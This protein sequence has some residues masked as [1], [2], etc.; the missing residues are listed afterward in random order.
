MIEAVTEDG[1]GA[2]PDIVGLQEVGNAGTIHVPGY[3]AHLH[4]RP[5]SFRFGGC[6]LLVR[7]ELH[8]N[9]TAVR[10]R[11]HVG[12][13]RAGARQLEEIVWVRLRLAD[14]T[15]L[16]VA[17][18]HLAADRWLRSPSV[19][20]SQREM[21]AQLAA[22]IALYS[23]KGL[24]AVL[25][26][27][28]RE[29]DDRDMTSMVQRSPASARGSKECL[30]RATGDLSTKWPNATARDAA[31]T[32]FRAGSRPTG[33][34]NIDH[35]YATVS[36]EQCV[37]HGVVYETLC[38]DGHEHA[39]VYAVLG[40]EPAR[41]AAS[42][43]ARPW[44]GPKGRGKPDSARFRH[45]ELDREPTDA[46]WR[47]DTAMPIADDGSALTA[48]MTL[49]EVSSH[50]TKVVRAAATKHAPP[51][52]Q[53][54]GE[55][56]TV[57]FLHASGADAKRMLKRERRARARAIAANNMDE[58]DAC[59]ARLRVHRAA[60][61]AALSAAAQRTDRAM[62]ESIK[63]ATSEDV[64]W[65]LLSKLYR[66]RRPPEVPPPIRVRVGS[67]GITPDDKTTAD[68]FR[69]KYD[70]IAGTAGRGVEE[71]LRPWQVR[72]RAAQRAVAAQLAAGADRRAP[73]RLDA[74]FTPEE[75]R[76]ALEQ[77]PANKAPGSDRLTYDLYKRV[78]VSARAWMLRMYNMAFTSGCV[79]KSW[80][81]S[82]IYV[83]HKKGP[84]TEAENYRLLYHANTAGKI[85]EKLLLNR[86]V[87]HLQSSGLLSR[88]QIG[89]LKK[90]SCD[91]HSFALATAIQ[92][93]QPDGPGEQP[94]FVAFL[95]SR[96]A[97][98]TTSPRVVMVKLWDKG[99][100]GK[101][102][103]AIWSTFGDAEARIHIGCAASAPF[104]ASGG[105]PEGRCASPI[106]YLVFVD[107]LIATLAAEPGILVGGASGTNISVLAFADDIA[108][109]ASS[110]SGLQRLLD[111]AARYAHEHAF[112]FSQKKSNTMVVG[113]GAAAVPP[114]A[115]WT[116][117]N[118]Y[119]D[120]PSADN[121][122]QTVEH[123]EYLG[124][125][126][127]SSGLWDEHHRLAANLFRFRSRRALALWGYGAAGLGSA[128]QANL[129]RSV[130]APVL[131]KSAAVTCASNTE[132][133]LH[134]D[135]PNSL[136][137]ID[138][139]W[140]ETALRAIGAPR[141]SHMAPIEDETGLV[142]T[143]ARRHAKLAGYIDRV[144]RMPDNALVRCVLSHVI[145]GT[146]G[147]KQQ[148]AAVRAAS[149]RS[150]QRWDITPTHSKH[151]ARDEMRAALEDEYYDGLDDDIG[152]APS[153]AHWIAV[154]A[155]E[156]AAG[157]HQQPSYARCNPWGQALLQQLR[158][159]QCFLRCCGENVRNRRCPHNG[160]GGARETPLHFV[161][162]CDA[163]GMAAPRARL[164]AALG[165]AHGQLTDEESLGLLALDAPATC[166]LEYDE[167]VRAV[168]EFMACC[169][170]KRFPG[171]PHMWA[172]SELSRRAA[173]RRRAA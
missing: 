37:A 85:Y 19:A 136:A 1:T 165:R 2:P 111:I 54:R 6:A 141:Q 91:D 121:T 72:F 161:G 101:M 48:H 156:E 80:T 173:T 140:V 45:R 112:Q 65:E 15:F 113:A 86:L 150:G 122:L 110:A 151:A 55:R 95:D 90:N 79:P 144:K 26:D 139:C 132:A 96:K 25:G 7:Q 100:R 5:D 8:D 22:Q 27:F 71:Q 89:F 67:S 98:P 28:N 158:T 128:V 74:P 36:A 163:P 147:S 104:Q 148:G 118:M 167:Y 105:L 157:L 64:R 50:I 40:L 9:G 33:G 11:D 60:F 61:R 42:P 43:Q 20:S 117:A 82:D 97:F 129:F 69:A 84:R 114:P 138:S 58:A 169:A 126:F 14:G 137:P 56:P 135:A 130:G 62:V 21:L 133:A 35:V 30:R 4:E 63:A 149:D 143:L 34:R 109:L 46:L 87:P 47:A 76:Q 66:F 78:H 70:A 127:S 68:A 39:P 31:M 106:C 145:E 152:R 159:G 93:G 3:H 131:D 23:A 134:R 102:W 32:E 38:A 146:A 13:Q 92:A 75:L 53:G 108:L 24:V 107:D 125:T 12:L 99:I 77:C 41:A 18:F 57:G 44:G 10:V 170:A 160:C 119:K 154:R 115:G 171:P 81:Q 162:Q 116:M 172:S 166:T 103:R 73:S 88:N 124:T 120:K 17:S 59:L 16:F 29:P 164:C 168:C 83:A 155:R 153:G 52:A 49:D 94:A 123:Y 142:R 51:R